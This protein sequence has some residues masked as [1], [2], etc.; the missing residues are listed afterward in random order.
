[1]PK[2]PH[3]VKAGA[4]VEYAIKVTNHGPSIANNIRVIEQLPIGT[5][6]KS[7]LPAAHCSQSDGHCLIGQLDV[8]QSID[9]TVVVEVDPNMAIATELVNN[10][11]VVS[12]AY[13][14]RTS[15]NADSAMVTVTTD[16]QLYVLKSGPTDAVYAGDTI[17]YEVMIE[18]IGSST[19]SDVQIRDNLPEEVTFV[20][21]QSTDS[22]VT[23]L[24]KSTDPEVICVLGDMSPGELIILVIQVKVDPA[25]LIGT[26]T[27]KIESNTLFAS[28]SDLIEET[29]IM[30]D[31]ENYRVEYT[32]SVDSIEPGNIVSY[33]VKVINEGSSTIRD[34]E[35]DVTL[36]DTLGYVSDTVGCG[37]ELEDCPLGDIPPGESRSFQI[38]VQID[39]DVVGTQQLVSIAQASALTS[40]G[41][42]TVQQT[43]MLLVSGSS[44]DEAIYVPFITR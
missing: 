14:D 19:I 1:M 24:N 40:Q 31:D 30:A 25:T 28:G 17:D 5:A 44:L 4:T 39:P 36:P 21:Y 15:N 34:V 13:D 43:S 3:T 37:V 42:V 20:S 16:K 38:L 29:T 12:D 26:I 22:D 2:P 6:I 33:D 10:V 27:N 8:N 41:T 35:V 18:N 9:I 23:C 7:V 11:R 32:A